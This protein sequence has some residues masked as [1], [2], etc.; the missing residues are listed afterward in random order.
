MKYYICPNKRFLGLLDSL[1]KETTAAIL[2]SS[3]E[4]DIKKLEKFPNK[5]VLYF[6]DVCEVRSNAFNKEIAT[7][8]KLFVSSISN[9]ITDMYICCD[10]GESRSSA[11]C[12]AL[13]K[14]Q[15]QDEMTIWRNPHY[16]P[17][18]LVYKLLCNELGIKESRLGLMYKEYINKNALRKAINRNRK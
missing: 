17:N 2:C 7:K 16:H 5:L 4:I 1:N 8:I 18:V 12:A 6:D 13:M 9:E 3:Y 15:K 14:L 10:S 11:I